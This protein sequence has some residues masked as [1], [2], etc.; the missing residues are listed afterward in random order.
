LGALCCTCHHSCQLPACRLDQIPDG[1]KD[2][3]QA[4][5]CHAMTHCYHQLVQVA[6]HFVA[7]GLQ[8]RSAGGLS[9]TQMMKRAAAMGMVSCYQLPLSLSAGIIL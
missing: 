3:D 6:L 8:L 4:E 2:Y 5:V 1:L 9:E 7:Q